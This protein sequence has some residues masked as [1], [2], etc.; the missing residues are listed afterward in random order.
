MPT[1]HSLL[2]SYFLNFDFLGLRGTDT[3]N[4]D[5]FSFQIACVINNLLL[6]A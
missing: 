5:L 4:M 3:W 1:S 6:Q 2:E